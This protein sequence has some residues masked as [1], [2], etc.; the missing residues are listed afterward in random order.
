MTKPGL[1][2]PITSPSVKAPKPAGAGRMAHASAQ[3][4]HGRVSPPAR[5]GGGIPPCEF[6]TWS[7][8]SHNLSSTNSYTLSCSFIRTMSGAALRT[9]AK[10]ASRSQQRLASIQRQLSSS[11]QPRKEVRDAYILAASRT[12][13]GV[14]RQEINKPQVYGTVADCGSSTANTPRYPQLNSEPLP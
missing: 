1:S 10:M 13:T 12:P 2:N 6:A 3:R 7:E 8:T 4:R 11:A 9:S 14:V 5:H